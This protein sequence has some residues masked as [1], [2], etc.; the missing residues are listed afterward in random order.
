VT[1]NLDK[2]QTQAIDSI[3]KDF[4]VLVVA[5]T[6]SGKTYIAEKAIEKYT[7]QNQNVIYTTPIKA[8]SNQ[9]YNDFTNLNIDTGLL[10]GDRSIKPDSELIVATTEILRN[11]IYSNDERLKQIGL[12]VLDEVHYLSDS[13]RGTTWEEIII[14]APKNIKFL[15]LSAT[16]RNKEEFHN[17]IVSLRGKTALV[18]SNIRPVPL[19]IS[20]VGLNPHNDQLKIIKSSKD[21]RN[22]KIFKFEKQ[23]RKY[24]RP[25][26]GFQLDYLDNKQL[27]PSI[28]FYFSRDRVETKARQATT[29]RKK[30]KEAEEVRKLFN[31]VFDSLDSVEYE[32]LNL[33]ELLWMWVRGVG[34]HHAGL[35]PIVKEFI[36]YLFLN[37][38]IKYLFATETLSLGLNLPAKSIVID[39]L[40]KFDGVKTRL[41]NQSEFLQLTGRAGRRGID[42]KGFAF[43]NYDRNIENFWY[44]NLFTLKSSNLNSAYSVSYSSILNMLSKYS[45]NEAV[46]LLENSFFAYQNNFNIKNLKKTFTSKLEVLELLKFKDNN[47]KSI[48]LTET[49]RDNLIV[50]LELLENEFNKDMNFYLMLVCSGLSTTRQVL[51]LNDIYMDTYVK[52]QI[53]EEKIN[54]MES[55]AGVKNTTSIEIGWFSI[56]NEYLHSQDIELVLTKFNISIGDFIRAGKEAS[57]LSTKLFNIYKLKEF[58]IISDMFSNELIQKT[59]R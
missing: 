57:E 23:Y 28:F 8:L 20:L 51:S 30:I 14:H 42:T 4:N 3:N 24:K 56:F 31:N 53:M 9:K 50:G 48:V 15:F 26:L 36:E 49:Y 10:T 44:N 22:N 58:K 37:R 11:M 27:T 6:G 17:W 12:I 39:R 55:F 7:K 41:I 1:F 35:A 43:I 45:L 54:K 40:Y 33:D 13:E 18:Y 19:E 21:K 16:I 34:Y 5:P 47:K 38:F 2:F 32:L 59:M 46:E 29:N 52:F 25:H